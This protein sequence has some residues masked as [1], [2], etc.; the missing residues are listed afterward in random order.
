MCNFI[1]V[2]CVVNF[3][4]DYLLNILHQFPKK[5]VEITWQ[6]W[7]TG[8]DW[9][10]FSGDFC[11][12]WVR[13]WSYAYVHNYIHISFFTSSSVLMSYLIHVSVSTF[14]LTECF[15]LSFK[16][17]SPAASKLYCTSVYSNFSNFSTFFCFC[18]LTMWTFLGSF[19]AKTSLYRTHLCSEH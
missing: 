6:S 2:Y 1:P 12:V 15:Q 17:A 13:V 10:W 3:H 7:L 16:S 8:C 19:L 4:R 18:S 9:M 11:F 5:G 14:V